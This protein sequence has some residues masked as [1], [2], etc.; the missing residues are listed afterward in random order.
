[1]AGGWLA[2][3]GEAEEALA[4]RPEEGQER[5]LPAALCLLPVGVPASPEWPRDN[6]FWD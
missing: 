1:M 5:S 2:G 4:G 3:L 6:T